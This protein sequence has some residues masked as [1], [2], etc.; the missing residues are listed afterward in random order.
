MA[1]RGFGKT[2][3]GS[4]W[5]HAQARRRRWLT[6][7]APTLDDVRELQIEGESGLLETAAPWFRPKWNANRRRL[8]Y[9]NGARVRYYTADEPERLRGKQHEVGWCE[10][11][12][13]W[14][15]PQA[16]DH[17][18]L[19]LRLGTD[20]RVCVTGTPKPVRII[21]DL[22][23]DPHCVVVRGTT[24]EN[25]ANLAGAF[26]D[27]VIRRYEGTR[28]G[29][30]ELLAH[31]LEED[32]EAVIPRAWVAER[33]QGEAAPH[34][35]LK[36]SG[37]G[38]DVAGGGA[39]DC[40]IALRSGPVY[41]VLKRWS[42]ADTTRTADEVEAAARAHGVTYINVDSIGIGQ[43]VADQLKRRRQQ[44]RIQARVNAINVAEA[45]DEPERFA[46]LRAQL[47]WLGRELTEAGAW[48]LSYLSEDAVDELVGPH[49]S[50]VRG[51]VQVE[52]KDKVK[53]RLGR[54]PDEADGILLAALGDRS[55]AGRVGAW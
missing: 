39:D 1:G 26:V 35:E 30:Q 45:S 32:S 40:V 51:K 18:I 17:F 15:Y 25:Q 44:G 22:V 13:S 23:A 41:T 28:L 4:E 42:E 43:G 46:N 21:R 47:W 27:E 31:L 55:G 38:V 52:P 14:R 48:N 33:C 11:P 12:G 37:L 54:S 50:Y 49:Y 5:I 2:R 19:G 53:L 24:Y 10:E 34:G 36:P 29:E 16:W 3:S 7:I 20:P 6:L 8:T 9:P